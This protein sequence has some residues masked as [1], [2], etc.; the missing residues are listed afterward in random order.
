MQDL[1]ITGNAV[2][3]VLHNAVAS[4]SVC[5][6]F[7]YHKRASEIG[8]KI[9]KFNISKPKK[10]TDRGGN[11]KTSWYNI[12]TMTVFQKDDGK[13]NRI[14][15]IPAI[16]LEANIFEQTDRDEKP[17]REEGAET[18]AREPEGEIN[19]EDIPY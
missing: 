5:G 2:S 18:P 11:E 3:G 15:E 9:T 12:G 17:R 14:I 10:Y 16:G 6:A 1:G 7:N 4:G 13:I 19:P 8:M